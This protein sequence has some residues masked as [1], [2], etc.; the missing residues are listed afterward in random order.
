MTEVDKFFMTDK[1]A[2]RISTLCT[3]VVKEHMAW[4]EEHDEPVNGS[5]M[6]TDNDEFTIMS[7]T[8]LTVSPIKSALDCLYVACSSM[9]DLGTVRG[10]GHPALVRSSL[11]G[12]TVSLWILD[13]DERTR[14][15]RALV[16]AHGQCKAER[17]FCQNLPSTWFVPNER[18]PLGDHYVNLTR[19][20]EGVLADGERQ[21]IDKSEVIKKP[22]D[23][24]IVRDA[25]DR[26]P[27][28]FLNAEPGAHVLS[29][30]RLLS[31]RAHGFHWPVR[32]AV[33]GRFDAETQRLIYPAKIP[34]GRFLG[35]I[36]IAMV[37]AR[38]AMDRFAFFA[39]I[40]PPDLRKPWELA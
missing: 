3:A 7:M 4:I 28:G 17:E 14:R 2:S 32:Y 39:G 38:V 12:S 6:Q 40:D 16:M 19:R 30:W 27:S 31:G 11:T 33:E 36:R 9:R 25:A 23:S 21:G 35:S 13:D 24:K 26:I 1:E 37:T 22:K 8:E 15:T 10:V 20:M 34:V 29:E 18:P 5:A